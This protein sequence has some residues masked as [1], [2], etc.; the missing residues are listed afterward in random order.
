MRVHISV[1]MEGV[2][3]IATLDQTIRGGS[4]YSRA[5][6]LMTAEANAAIRGAF[7]GGATEVVVSDSH[8]TMDNLLHTD[9]DPRATL[10][11]GS[12]RPSCMVQGLTREDALAVFVGYHAAA[13]DEGVLAHTFSSSFTELRINGVAASE[14]DVNGLYAGSLGVP[15]AVLTGDD[16]IC[17]A[18][19]KTFPDLVT[20]PV[21]KA[22]GWSA[23]ATLSPSVACER[24]ESAVASAVAA[25]PPAPLA[26]PEALVLE[27]DFSVPGMAD[28]AMSVPGAVRVDGA[29]VRREVQDA[30]ELLGLITNWYF[31]AGLTARQ[32]AALGLRV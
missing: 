1:D 19:G 12:P 31:L 28:L 8:G 17:A 14:A 32:L 11:F 27:V 3:G 7:A 2:A 16:Q 10:V 4:G 21:K 24:I 15:V 26:V 25:A 22:E 6:A 29:T 18:A 13:G 9:L 30:G 20:V 23:A 5:Q